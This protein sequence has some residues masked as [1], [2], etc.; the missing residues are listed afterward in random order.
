MKGQ[1]KYHSNMRKNIMLAEVAHSSA[2][3][4]QEK[5]KTAAVLA[6]ARKKHA[7][8]E[9]FKNWQAIDLDTSFPSSISETVIRSSS[10]GE[11]FTLAEVSNNCQLFACINRLCSPGSTEA[12][13]ARGLP[14]RAGGIGEARH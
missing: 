13:E 12:Q 8:H 2:K 4:E 3:G 5:H 14:K 10:S 7:S 11:E 6:K 9:A 1:V